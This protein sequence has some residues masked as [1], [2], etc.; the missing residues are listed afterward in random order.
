MAKRR[1]RRVIRDNIPELGVSLL[2]GMIIG[3]HQAG[4]IGSWITGLSF[5]A[6]CAVLLPIAQEEGEQ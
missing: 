1:K 5:M 4:V 6:V 2:L 3:Y